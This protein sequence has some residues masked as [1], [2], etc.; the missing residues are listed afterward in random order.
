MEGGGAKNDD[1]LGMIVN[2]F[3]NLRLVGDKGEIKSIRVIAPVKGDGLRVTQ[4]DRD[5][6]PEIFGYLVIYI[7]SDAK[8]T[9]I[10]DEPN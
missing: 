10:T 7:Y 2:P 3:L 8:G 1:D 5:D 4:I 6:E 9:H